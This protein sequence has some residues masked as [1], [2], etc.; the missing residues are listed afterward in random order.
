MSINKVQKHLVLQFYLK[1]FSHRY[2]ILL[3]HFSSQLQYNYTN[4]YLIYLQSRLDTKRQY[5]IVCFVFF[6]L[7]AFVYNNYLDVSQTKYKNL[8][9]L[10][11]SLIGNHLVNVYI[12]FLLVSFTF[13][14]QKYLPTILMYFIT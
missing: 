7:L 14:V 3:Y 11:L 4:F 12:I 1:L 2:N 5:V 6:C 10:V 9:I 8:C 13:L